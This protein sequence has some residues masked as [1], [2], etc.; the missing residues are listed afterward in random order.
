MTCAPPPAP[1]AAHVAAAEPAVDAA[2]PQPSCSTRW[3]AAPGCPPSSHAVA[4]D[5]R[6]EAASRTGWPFTRWVQRLRPR[7]LRRLRLDGRDVRVSR[8]RRALGARPLVAA[9]AD[10]RGPRAAV[11]LATRRL[12]DRAGPRPADPVGRGGRASGH[13]RRAASLGDA[14]DQAVVGT[15]LH[16]RA[17]VWWRVVGRGPA[18]SS[19]R[20]PWP[21]CCGSRSTSCSG[22]SSSTPS[23]GEPPTWGVLPVPFVLLVGGLLAGL[24]LA[25]VSRWLARIGARRRGRVMDQRLR[26]SIETVARRT[27]SSC[28][29]SGCS[30]ATRPRGG[31]EP[32]R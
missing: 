24:L 14:L 6:M 25:L 30:S 20:P 31:A 11:D 29:S 32:R 1:S 18:R 12:A 28:P 13:A 9:A 26:A 16:A 17:P 8:R 21:G 23:S 4:R 10:T 27:A 15:S 22:G 3:P 5:Y 19:P 7:P 2:G